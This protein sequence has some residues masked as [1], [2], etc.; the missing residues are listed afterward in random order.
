MPVSKKQKLIL[1]LFLL[2]EVEEYAVINH[3]LSENNEVH[4]M[5]LA[6]KTEGGFQRAY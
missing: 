4:Q 2:Q 1:K 5:F 3:I 6:R